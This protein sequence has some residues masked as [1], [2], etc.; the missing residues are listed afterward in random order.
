MDFLL[1]RLCV[2][3]NLLQNNLFVILHPEEMTALP[4]VYSIVHIDI[5]LPIICLTSNTHEPVEY[6]CGVVLMVQVVRKLYD[7]CI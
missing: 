5:G 1:E 7:V 4:Q 6:N 3:E 2:T